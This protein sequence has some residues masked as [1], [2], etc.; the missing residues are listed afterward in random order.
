MAES[1]FTYQG[2]PPSGMTLVEGAANREVLLFPGHEV[3]LPADH[4]QVR[5]LVAQGRLVPVEPAK[6]AAAN[7]PQKPKKPSST[8]EK[9]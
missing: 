6:A 1:T 5:A 3:R 2:G 9:R 4:P 8:K 7:A